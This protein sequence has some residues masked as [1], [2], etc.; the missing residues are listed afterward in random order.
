M[1]SGEKGFTILEIVIGISIFLLGML[2]VAALEISAIKAEA[3]SIRMTEATQ[4]ARGVFE[5]LMSVPYSD[6]KLDDSDC[7]GWNGAALA[8]T[9]IKFL[10]G[11]VNSIQVRVLTPMDPEG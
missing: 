2:G 8:Q 5:E 6:P 9:R 10:R 4:L 11:E 1:F 7:S 3:F